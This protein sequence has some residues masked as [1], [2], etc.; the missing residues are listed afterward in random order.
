[1]SEFTLFLYSGCNPKKSNE[2]DKAMGGAL[3]FPSC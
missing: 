3:S 1:M 2:K